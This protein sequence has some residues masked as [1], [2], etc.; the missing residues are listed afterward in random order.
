MIC[1]SWLSRVFQK[2]PKFLFRP[3]PK[4]RLIQKMVLCGDL[5][6]LWLCLISQSCRERS[7]LSEHPYLFSD[8]FAVTGENSKKITLRKSFTGYQKWERKWEEAVLPRRVPIKS[9]WIQKANWLLLLYLQQPHFRS[10]LR[11]CGL[12]VALKLLTLLLL[13][14]FTL[15]LPLCS[16]CLSLKPWYLQLKDQAVGDAK[17]LARDLARDC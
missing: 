1:P 13:T 12:H 17:D 2:V 11:A 5:S 7:S 15:P 4:E 14:V 10:L 8:S 6:D 3:A 9:L 16:L